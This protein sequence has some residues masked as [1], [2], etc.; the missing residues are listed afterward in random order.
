MEKAKLLFDEK[1]VAAAAALIKTAKKEIFIL[2]YL[3]AVPGKKKPGRE[4]LLYRELFKV[5]KRGVGC[6][7][8]INYGMPE[9]KMIKQNMG[10]SR[11]LTE[12]GAK[13]KAVGRNRTVHAKMIIIDGVSLIMGSHNWTARAMER[14]VEASIQVDNRE[15]V[16]VARERFLELWE[17]AECI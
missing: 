12:M 6:R 2:A 16:K 9:N 8:I 14:N 4:E 3:M 7:V 10:A 13:C 15:V 11:Y 17:K 5:M 1:F